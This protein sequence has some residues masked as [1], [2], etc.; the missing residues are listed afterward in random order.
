MP[1]GQAVT[2]ERTDSV[3]TS[4]PS[5][6]YTA[7]TDSASVLSYE[8]TGASP[9]S[10]LTVEWRDVSLVGNASDPSRLTFRA[11]LYEGTNVVEFHY[12]ALNANGG[13]APVTGGSATIGLESATGTDGFQY[14][15]NQPDAVVAGAA[16]QFTPQ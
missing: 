6:S 12:C 8:V 3:P 1:A 5:F 10:V 15:F 11:K 16:L 13:T 9:A 4:D 7:L 14:S 2:S